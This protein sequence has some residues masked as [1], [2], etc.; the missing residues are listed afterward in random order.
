VV[1]EVPGVQDG[2]TLAQALAPEHLQLV[3]PT[4]EA[5]ARDVT[6]AGCVF[7]GASAGT[8]FGDYIAGSNH[9]LP[10]NGAA[11]FDSALSPATFR[12]RFT[13]VAIDD[14]GPLVEAA[15]PVAR[16]EGFELHARS[17]EARIRDNH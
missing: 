12:R 10:T 9:I 7:V 6:R 5:L 15:A 2:L 13:E 11:R 16:S 8:A 17:M 4:A 1:V 14:P 3:G